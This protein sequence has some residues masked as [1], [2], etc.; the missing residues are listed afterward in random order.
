[1]DRDSAA[2]QAPEKH[3][4]NEDVKPKDTVDE[5]SQESFPASDPPSWAGGETNA[6]KKTP[7]PRKE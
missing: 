1:M 7:P 4:A 2:R 6:N 5:S 3:P